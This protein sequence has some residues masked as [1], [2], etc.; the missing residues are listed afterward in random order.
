MNF[1]KNKCFI[2]K[3]DLLNKNFH[4]KNKLNSNRSISKDSDNQTKD[5]NYSYK[6]DNSSKN[7]KSH[8]TNLI[9][10]NINHRPSQKS[11]FKEKFNNYVEKAKTLN[12]KILKNNFRN[13]NKIKN[14]LLIDSNKNM[15]RKSISSTMIKKYKSFSQ[16][17]NYLNF[18]KSFVLNKFN[19]Q[20]PLR[21]S[22]KQKKD[23]LSMFK[24]FTNDIINESSNSYISD[25]STVKLSKKGNDIESEKNGI[26]TPKT[27]KSSNRSKKKYS[28]KKNSISFKDINNKMDI[29]SP[30]HTRSSFNKNYIYS[31]R[32]TDKFSKTNIWK[33]TDTNNSNKNIKNSTIAKSF[34]FGTHFK[35]DTNFKSLK[36]KI[37]QSIILRPEELDLSLDEDNKK[38]RYSLFNK[39]RISYINRIK[40]NS[41]NLIFNNSLKSRNMTPVHRIRN[42][43]SKMNKN[44]LKNISENE[45]MNIN[46][47]DSPSLLREK[48][49][50][51]NDNIKSRKPSNNYKLE[52]FPFF[53]V[54]R[55]YTFFYEKFRMLEKRSKVYDSL[56]DEKY[57]DQVEINNYLLEP[58]SFFNI[59]FDS[60]L[61]IMTIFIMIE[62]PFYLSMNLNFC[63]RKT[64]TLNF[65]I[66]IFMDILCIVDLFLGFFR[67][68]YNWEEQLITKPRLIA[69]NYIKSWFF[70]DLIAS[71]PFYTINKIYEPFCNEE[72][73]I[74]NY[75][76]VILNNIHYIF[77]YNKLLKVIKAFGNN[78]G[79]KIVSD[80]LNEYGSIKIRIILNI[81][82]ALSS[83]NYAACLYIFV[84]RNSY[85]NWIFH[86]KLETES[87][88]NIYISAVYILMMALT[89]VGYGD[90]T[91]YSLYEIIF[92][93][94]LLIIGIIAYSTMV[95]FLS[96]YII[97]INERSAD[98]EKK[99]LI[100]DEVKL[101][102][103]NLPVELYDRIKR[104]LKF[105]NFHE[106]KL[107]NI[108]FDCLPI[109]LKNS[110]ISEMYRPMIKK[111][112]FFKNFQN[113]DFI[114]RVILALKPIMAYKNDILV[115]E[116]DMIKDIMFVKKGILTVELLINMENPQENIDKF[117]N[118]TLTVEKGPFVTKIGNSTIISENNQDYKKILNS[119][120]EEDKRSS[121]FKIPSTYFNN[122]FLLKKRASLNYRLSFIEL[123]KRKKEKKE[124]QKKKNMTYVKIIGIRENEHFGDVLMF[125]EQR[126]PLRVRVKTKKCEMLFLKKIDAIKISSSYQ[127]IW[128]RINKKSI[129]NFEHI[130]ESIKKIIEIYSSAKKNITNKEDPS[131]SYSKKS[132]VSQE[133]NKKKTKSKKKKM[134]LI[135]INKTLKNAKI[136]Y[137]KYFKTLDQK[138]DLILKDINKTSSKNLSEKH[139]NK[140][141]IDESFD[142]NQ[143]EMILSTSS[144]FS[145]KKDKNIK[146][147]KKKSKK[148]IKNK[149]KKADKNQKVDQRI[150]D[151]FQGNY[152]FYKAHNQNLNDNNND[153]IISEK[154]SQEGSVNYLKSSNSIRNISTIKK[155]FLPRNSLQNF[156]SINKSFN[157][158]ISKSINKSKSSFAYMDSRNEDK[159]DKEEKDK[160]NESEQM[161][162]KY[163]CNELNLGELIKVNSGE[164]LLYKKID[165]NS[166]STKNNNHDINKNINNLQTL[167]NT[168]GKEKKNIQIIN[169]YINN[170]K[171][172]NNSVNINEKADDTY[173]SI[174]ANTSNNIEIN[175]NFVFNIKNNIKNDRTYV[176]LS[177]ISNYR[178]E[179]KN[180]HFNNL[181]INNNISFKINESYENLNVISK[182]KLIKDKSLQ[183]KLKKFIL[184]ELQNIS[185]NHN[186]N[187]FTKEILS[188]NKKLIIKTN[189][190][191]GLANQMKFNGE[192]KNFLSVIKPRLRSSKSII[193]KKGQKNPFLNGSYKRA[194]SLS[195]SQKIK[196]SSSFYD[197]VKA[198][199]NGL[200][201]KFFNIHIENN[202]HFSH[203]GLM[204]HQMNTSNGHRIRRN[205]VEIAPYIKSKKRKDNLLSKISLNIQK[206]SQ[207]LNNPEEFYNN[208][209]NSLL[210]EEIKGI[211]GMMSK[212]NDFLPQES[213][214]KNK[215]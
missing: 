34:K 119:I 210:I 209:F 165:L 203:K 190:L 171:E 175:N 126:S 101:E 120:K 42:S 177:P 55:K 182:E 8:R 184:D 21:S 104:H 146:K 24:K 95:S 38:Y 201:N 108:V 172:N 9:Y 200:E 142:I 183:Q 69:K 174:G 45:S 157:K 110:L 85:P 11:K 77:M 170:T 37:G 81:C 70:V 156:P 26:I 90:I 112:I 129:Y 191:G 78:Q 32:N 84:G 60:I 141:L 127:N 73:F 25:S 27:L 135:K 122:P 56:D 98:Y 33:R 82:L 40:K 52:D 28:I 30:I 155:K 194:N 15:K 143:E 2:P 131:P 117:M 133:N 106:K 58:D 105:K 65:L 43:L 53:N 17:N 109:G 102:H 36:E 163:V 213:V 205:S 134:E 121:V 211:Q 118:T 130:K 114:V 5:D 188:F 147:N 47:V 179:Q 150:L 154:V 100:L 176:S 18:K 57:E 180:F 195:L 75:Y 204:S 97:K 125:L 99:V 67:A 186:H 145:S 72:E 193:K 185:E 198:R 88:I 64:I 96:N 103:P 22:L 94:L 206:T 181:S 44:D 168:L 161:Y 202:K 71:I 83:I 86:S 212:R 76:N 189:S 3:A 41:F 207:N 178:R 160:D 158:S 192:K 215:K 159:D 149:E 164:N 91:C 111:F 68:Y 19:N 1:N 51:E 197:G 12:N 173:S 10:N 132:D 7:S 39:K 115:N 80:K 187:S 62:L 199:I 16:E 14:N 31:K 66:N 13:E 167:L 54:K 35:N 23:I 92:Q 20:N 169:K 87:F 46:T 48:N 214:R 4:S 63:K 153:T 138:D 137:S 166:I 148:T 107:K 79:W 61:F 124:L 208:Y 113:R 29:R 128:S 162:N 196:R 74:S 89:T 116:G 152:K 59:F 6:K 139:L 136:N 123:E 50:E 151:A 93:L 140:I 144:S 49:Q